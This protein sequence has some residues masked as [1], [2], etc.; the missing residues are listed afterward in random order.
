MTDVVT[1]TAGADSAATTD[2][3]V[4]A[5]GTT[6]QETVQQSAAQQE[7]AKTDDDRL[8]RLVQ[9]KVDRLMADERKKNAELQKQL[10][11]LQK[12]KLSDDEIKQLEISEREKTI[13]DKEKEL[14]DRENR[15]YAIKAIKAAGLDDGSDNALSLI[16]FVI[17]DNEEAMNSRTKAFK[18]LVNKMV[19]AQVDKTF[20]ANG[21]TPNSSNNGAHSESKENNIAVK[22]GKIKAEQSKKSNDILNHYLGGKK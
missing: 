11:A 4:A 14:A 15:L 21:R 5:T 20:K 18:A 19:S 22:L 16:D 10:N 6:A 12:E 17:A 13:A 9:S 2:T 3:A 1:S 8:D 7:T